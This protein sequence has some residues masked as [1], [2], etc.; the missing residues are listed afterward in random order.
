[1]RLVGADVSPEIASRYASGDQGGASPRC[2]NALLGE[3]NAFFRTTYN[4]NPFPMHIL[5]IICLHTFLIH[6]ILHL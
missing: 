6:L 4:I 5:Q 1:M 3:V 2:V